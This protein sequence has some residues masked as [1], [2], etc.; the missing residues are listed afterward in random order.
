MRPGIYTIQRS[1]SCTAERYKG[2]KGKKVTLT[3]AAKEAA[4]NA[5]AKSAENASEVELARVAAAVEPKGIV[6]TNKQ[7]C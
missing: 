1:I 7:V 6:N 2:K 3:E 5:D 4:A